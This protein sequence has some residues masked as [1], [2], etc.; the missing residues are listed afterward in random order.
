MGKFFSHILWELDHDPESQ[1][2][3]IWGEGLGPPGVLTLTLVHAELSTIGQLQF[4]FPYHH[5]VSQA[6][7]L[8]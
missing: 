7:L 4:Q 3:N 5:L 2:Y 6:S 1:S 8:W